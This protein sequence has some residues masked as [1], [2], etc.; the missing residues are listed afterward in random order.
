MRLIRK[1]QEINYL[2]HGERIGCLG[3]LVGGFIAVLK[4]LFARNR[5]TVGDA[6]RLRDA[7][8]IFHI[9]FPLT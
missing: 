3:I 7:H 2:M 5:L 9:D 8:D 1:R 4:Y 6:R